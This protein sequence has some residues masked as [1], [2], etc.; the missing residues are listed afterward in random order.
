MPGAEPSQLQGSTVVLRDWRLDD[1]GRYR[2]WLRP[3]HEWH[4]WDGPYFPRP[5]EVEAD[6]T[7]AGLRSQIME[8]Q[9]PSPR[10]NWSLPTPSVTS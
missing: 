1:L 7:C 3:Q 4:A 10:T 2:E 9:W 6:R 8:A 5:T